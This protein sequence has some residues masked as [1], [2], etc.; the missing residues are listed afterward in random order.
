MHTTFSAINMFWNE[1]EHCILLGLRW[2]MYNGYRPSHSICNGAGLRGRANDHNN[3]MER[4]R[5]P[6]LFTVPYFSIRSSRS[7]AYRYGRPR[8]IQISEGTVVG[9]CN[10]GRRVP[11]SQ[12]SPAFKSDVTRD[13][14]QRRFLARHSI[15]TLFRMV[16]TLLQHCYVALKIVVANR[17]V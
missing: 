8:R 2:W 12:T 6:G 5:F 16:T 1:K 13:D 10:G 9:V 7:R 11:S 3:S 4:G 15:T 17:L 14:W